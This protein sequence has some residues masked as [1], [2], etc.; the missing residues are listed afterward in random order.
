MS[1]YY[2]GVEYASD[3]EL[4]C[5]YDSLNYFVCLLSLCFLQTYVASLMDDFFFRLP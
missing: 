4:V 1:F 3:L 2:V 5:I